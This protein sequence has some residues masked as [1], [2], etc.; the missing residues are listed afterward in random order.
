MFKNEPNSELKE[1]FNGIETILA[2]QVPARDKVEAIKERMNKIHELLPFRTNNASLEEVKKIID[3]IHS[4]YKDFL[5]L[6]DEN[7]RL[8]QGV[9][10]ALKF[11]NYQKIL[12]EIA[13]SNKNS[14]AVFKA[15]AGESVVKAYLEIIYC[16]AT[17]ITF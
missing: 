5:Q 2:E 7:E 3:E 13:W 14:E 1:H 16:D 9:E 17:G 12:R 4:E 6:T 15:Q 8:K 11:K 10:Y